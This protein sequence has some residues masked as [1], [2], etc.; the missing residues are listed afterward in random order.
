MSVNRLPTT[1]KV[2]SLYEAP[3]S[4]YGSE[5]TVTV[6]SGAIAARCRSAGL[7][8]LPVPAGRGRPE[9]LRYVAFDMTVT[10]RETAWTLLHGTA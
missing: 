9:G 10:V 2:V 7:L 5:W 6:K 1:C 4:L 8:A 3:A